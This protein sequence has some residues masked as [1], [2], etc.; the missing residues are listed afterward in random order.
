ML[1]R[2]QI[3]EWFDEARASGATHM[4]VVVDLYGR[5]NYS[6]PVPPDRDPVEFVAEWNAKHMIT[7]LQVYDLSMDRDTQLAESDPWHVAAAPTD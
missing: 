5:E 2:L 6:V 3:S 4:L 1:G 7:V